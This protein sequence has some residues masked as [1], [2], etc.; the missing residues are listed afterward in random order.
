VP[1][2]LLKAS[3]KTDGN[4]LELSV[5][6]P[7]RNEEG[8]VLPI[9]NEVNAE[10]APL[11]HFEIICVDDGSDD[12]TEKEL[13]E[14]KIIFPKL[15]IIQHIQPCG[16]STATRTGI[17]AAN[18]PWIVTLDGDGQNPPSEILNLVSARE[19]A[20]GKAPEI[21]PLMIAGQRQTREDDWFRRCCSIGANGLRSLVLG[22]GIR[23]TGCSL[24]LFRRDTFLDLPYFDHMHRFLPALVQ[25]AGGHVITVDVKHRPRANGYTKYGLMNRLWTGI[26]DL[27]GVLWL[28]RRA[29]KPTINELD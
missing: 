3:K 5:V 19:H 27:L 13:R 4:S 6:I 17:C 8:N 12:N 15:R 14:A 2:S 1:K 7:M 20:L 24:K 16:Q 26:L 23:D 29:K 10:L 22:D 28:M 9:I 11:K 18:A 21:G 25:R